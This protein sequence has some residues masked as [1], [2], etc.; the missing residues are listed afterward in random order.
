MLKL[1]KLILLIISST[2]LHSQ[3]AVYNWD[4]KKD[5]IILG[6]GTAFW[7]SYFAISQQNKKITL[8]DINQLNSDNIW[9]FDRGAIKHY[10]KS[11]A[12]TSDFLLYG[13]VAL[14]FCNFMGKASRK[15]GLAIVGMFI[16][17]I[18]VADGMIN[19]IK[20]TTKRYR[21]FTYN[22]DVPISNKLS[23][24]ARYSFVS[25][26]VGT[27]AAGSFFAAKVFSDIYPNSKWKKFVWTT[28]IAIPALTG[29]MRFK[30]GKH[31]PTDVLGGYLVGASI[32]YLIPHLHLA[33]EERIGFHII[34]LPNSGF[35]ASFQFNINN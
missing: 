11:A 29:Y 34:P 22:P 21:P 14:P 25:G 27:S 19:T 12:N 28:A 26:H 15:E 4:L 13:S 5:A 16:E 24:D 2:S 10:S 17:T 33:K 7:A 9:S 3:T 31:Y 8:D 35:V 20:T 6:T 1:V 23:S 18:L 32:G 30:A